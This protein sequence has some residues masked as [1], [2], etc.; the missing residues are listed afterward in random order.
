M[1]RL[2]FT[3]IYLYR[4]YIPELIGLAND[5]ETVTLVQELLI[6]PKPYSQGNMIR[7]MPTHSVWQGLCHLVYNF[8]NPISSSAD[9]VQIMNIGNNMYSALSQ[10]CRQGL[11][12]LTDFPV[13]NNLSDI[14]YQLTYSESY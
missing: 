3:Q 1:N 6:Q 11:L 10:L 14:N 8:I 2:W 13:M 4:F 12:M 7:Q 5:V 9:L